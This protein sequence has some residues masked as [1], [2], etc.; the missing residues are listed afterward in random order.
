[1]ITFLTSEIFLPSFLAYP[2]FL[3]EM[4][5]LSETAKVVYTVLKAEQEELDEKNNINIYGYIL[6]SLQC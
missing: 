5:G 6:D 1:M 3:L 2:K 4:T